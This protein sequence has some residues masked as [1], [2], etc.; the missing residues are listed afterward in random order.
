M[1]DEN[2]NLFMINEASF[3]KIYANN[4]KNEM[5]HMSSLCQLNNII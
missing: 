1:Y 3:L 4:N 5:K 2:I